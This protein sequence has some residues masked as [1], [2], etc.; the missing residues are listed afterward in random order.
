[1]PL[2]MFQLKSDLIKHVVGD[3]VLKNLK[4]AAILDIVEEQV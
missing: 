3:V 4:M 2:T 1:M